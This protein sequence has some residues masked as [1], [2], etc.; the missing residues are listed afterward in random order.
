[1]IKNIVNL[2]IV[3]K[4]LLICRVFMG[5]TYTHLDI[6]EDKVNIRDDETTKCTEN[7]QF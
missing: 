3:Q 1:M 5:T 4:E 7:E 6:L 2:Q